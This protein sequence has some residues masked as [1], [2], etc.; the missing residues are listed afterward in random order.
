MGS[1]NGRSSSEK[2]QIEFFIC[3]SGAINE[4]LLTK[5]FSKRID[6]TTR[7]LNDYG[8]ILLNYIQVIIT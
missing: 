2:T 6:N 5:L 8:I 7:Q 4:D 3:S 1:S